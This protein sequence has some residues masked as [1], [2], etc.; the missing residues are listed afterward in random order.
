MKREVVVNG[1]VTCNGQVLL[2]K[3]EEME[4]H[5]ISGEWHFPG[6]HLEDRE[7]PEE[8]IRR[9]IR[10]ETGLD[11][12]VHQLLDATTTSWDD[13]E[14][15]VRLLFHCESEEMDAEPMDD[16]TETKWVSP[17]RVE[18]QEGSEAETVKNRERIQNFLH[19]LEKTPV[20]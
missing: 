2:G 3:K 16:L 20:F 8:T 12:E 1:I 15:P 11:V 19:K 4:G 18:K 5:P 13:V 14:K 9:E 10:E 7:E 17:D 6:G